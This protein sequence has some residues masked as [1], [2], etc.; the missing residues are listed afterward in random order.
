MSSPMSKGILWG[1]LPGSSQSS[2]SWDPQET[3]INSILNL[4]PKP[5]PF[6]G[7]L[8][9]RAKDNNAVSHF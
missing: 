9:F 3:K 2:L 5:T 6:M 8:E 7:F 1:L 4:N